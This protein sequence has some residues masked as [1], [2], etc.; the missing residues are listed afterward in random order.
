M[1]M[2]I[3]VVVVVVVMMMMMIKVYIREIWREDVDCIQVA[4]DRV[5]WSLTIKSTPV[6]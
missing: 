5:Q 1:V 2:V 3:V 4:K 6:T